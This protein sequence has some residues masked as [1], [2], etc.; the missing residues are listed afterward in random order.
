MPIIYF[1]VRKISQKDKF[2]KKKKSNKTL[3]FCHLVS[4][5]NQSRF[6]FSFEKKDIENK[7]LFQL[8]KPDIQ[9]QNDYI[10]Q[11]ILEIEVNLKHKKINKPTVDFFGTSTIVLDETEIENIT[12]YVIENDSNFSSFYAT[13]FTEPYITN[14]STSSDKQSTIKPSFDCIF[15]F[16]YNV[17]NK[18]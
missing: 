7:F 9:N 14:N 17:S 3:F 11:T 4:E 8:K 18:M 12:D 6:N 1:Q 16:I 15:P 5:S 13:K 2:S 10:D